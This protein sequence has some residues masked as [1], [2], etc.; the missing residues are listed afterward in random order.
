MTMLAEQPLVVSLILGLLGVLLL[1]GWLQTGKKPPAIV[2]LVFLLLI[3]FAWVI[4]SHVVTDRERIEE[5]IYEVATAVEAEDYEK[6]YAFIGD[7]EALRRARVELPIYDFDMAK[8]NSIRRITLVPSSDPL[9]A[10]VD[11]TVKVDVS[12][13]SG[14]MRHMRGPR[15]IILKLQKT[16]Q[17]EWKVIQYQHLPIAGGPDQFSNITP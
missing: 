7:P 12:M 11:M 17:D 1:Y 2:G 15:R 8:V 5:L 9:E 10:D 6:V 13:T 4:A 16:G 14:A 3:P